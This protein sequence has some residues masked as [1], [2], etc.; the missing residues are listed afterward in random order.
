MTSETRSWKDCS[1]LLICF[2][3][4]GLL[5]I[6]EFHQYIVRTFQT[7]WKSPGGE[8]RLPDN[9]PHRLLGVWVDSP[10]QAFPW[11]CPFKPAWGDWAHFSVMPPLIPDPQYLC[12]KI[13]IY[14]FKQQSSGVLWHSFQCLVFSCLFHFSH[15]GKYVVLL[16]CGFTLYISND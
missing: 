15:S 8:L 2:V 10:N 12:E 13:I 14:C 5:I 1:F 3:F 7:L 16:N 11:L 6:G 4:L 9:M